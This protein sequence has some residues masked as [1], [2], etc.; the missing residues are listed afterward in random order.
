VWRLSK[1]RPSQ[2]IICERSLSCTASHNYSTEDCLQDFLGGLCQPFVLSRASSRRQCTVTVRYSMLYEN[3]LDVTS[4]RARE[5]GLQ[6]SRMRLDDKLT[7]FFR[8]LTLRNACCTDAVETWRSADGHGPPRLSRGGVAH[9]VYVRIIAITET[10]RGL[11]IFIFLRSRGS[12]NV[13]PESIIWLRQMS[14]F[15]GSGSTSAARQWVYNGQAKFP[16]RIAV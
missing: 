9:E 10:V 5:S 12:Y 8:F 6:L 13:I 14:C 3:A 4:V 1:R 15:D 16:R 2:H 11:T 7:G